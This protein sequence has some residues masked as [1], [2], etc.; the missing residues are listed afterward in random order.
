[1]RQSDYPFDAIVAS[2]PCTVLDYCSRMQE[3]VSA[4]FFKPRSVA[5]GF[6]VVIAPI[7][8]SGPHPTIGTIK[9]RL[10]EFRI[11]RVNQ[12]FLG[13]KNLFVERHGFTT[14]I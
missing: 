7:R 3:C 5:A 4:A 13:G 9:I 2:G 12:G 8:R 6:K 11:Q 10:A 14:G 1:M